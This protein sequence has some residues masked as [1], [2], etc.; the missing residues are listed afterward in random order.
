MKVN[1]KD[2]EKGKIED[3]QLKENDVVYVPETF[4]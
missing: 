4:F 2:I 1:V 3:I